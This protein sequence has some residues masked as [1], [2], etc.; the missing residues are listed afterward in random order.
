ML[1]DAGRRDMS[2]I[3]KRIADKYR[4]LATEDVLRS[5]RL[6][7]SDLLQLT[8]LPARLIFNLYFHHCVLTQ[9]VGSRVTCE[10]GV[11]SATPSS[12]CNGIASNGDRSLLCTLLRLLRYHL[13]CGQTDL[14]AFSRPLLGLTS[15]SSDLPKHLIPI[16]PCLFLVTCTCCLAVPPHGLSSSTLLSW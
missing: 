12:W 15:W 2:E 10:P 16:Q 1:E 14:H 5:S 6:A 3:H 8:D 13:D 11:C 4:R 9:S 7:L